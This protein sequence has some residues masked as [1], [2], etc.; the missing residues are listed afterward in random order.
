[1]VV[2]CNNII[3]AD[4]VCIADNFMKRFLGLMGKKSLGYGE[5]LLL[6]NSP[7]I[8]CFFMRMPIDVIYLSKDLKVLG[9]ETL[10]PWNIGKYIKKT[11]HI[12][13]LKE[14]AALNIKA[15]DTILLG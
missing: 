11:R 12:L 9:I 15:G 6:L 2:Y 1:M 7:S 8:H 3:L 4:K 14:G 5:G 13:E 10:R